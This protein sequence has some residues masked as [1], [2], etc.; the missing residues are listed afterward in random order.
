MDTRR[1][2]SS[3]VIAALL[4][5]GSCVTSPEAESKRQDMEADIDEIMSYE[6]DKTEFGDPKNCLSE[7]EYRS[8]RPLGDR[9]LLFEGRNDKQWIN[10]LRGRCVGLRNDGIFIMRQSTAGRSCDMDRFDAVDR[11]NALLSTGVGMGPNCVLGEFI[12]VA[13]AQV[14]EIEARLEM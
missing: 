10:V 7:N 4:A 1:I 9:H 3:A 6:L 13:K 8:F 5:L 2:A 14:Q 11:S 12:P